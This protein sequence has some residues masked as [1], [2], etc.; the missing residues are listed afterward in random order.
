MFDQEAID[1]FNQNKK[2]QEERQQ[3]LSAVDE[4]SQ[5]VDGVKRAIETAS[6]EQINDKKT[7]PQNVNILNNLATPGDISKVV[8]SLDKLAVTLK[9]EANDDG[10][11]IE[12]INSLKA[13]LI[14]LPSEMPEV[15]R[16]EE[17][18][19][20]NLIEF[21]AY[22][23]P[24]LDA[25]NK[26]ELNPTFTP[27]IEVKPADVKITT[28]KLDTA[29]LLKSI[30]KLSQEFAKLASKEQ[31][32]P[33]I[34]PIIEA[35]KATTKAINNLTFPV[36]NY[37]LPYKDGDKATQVALINGA[38]PTISPNLN[39]ILDTATSPILYL[40]KAP[41]ASVTSSAVWQIAKLDTTSGLTKTWAGNA[42]FTQIWDNRTGLTFN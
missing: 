8:A 14:K 33:D 4:I 42:G 2:E 39:T 36:P 27:K 15:E 35:T 37:V 19:I 38:I 24:L 22:I 40:G 17:V 23:T 21:K 30:E 9:P 6:Q 25:I 12:A 7:N 34:T 29:P 20:K 1:A 31:T 26:L 16:V 13:Q 28:E 11:V 5:K 41:L 32:E 3:A 18:S 10:P